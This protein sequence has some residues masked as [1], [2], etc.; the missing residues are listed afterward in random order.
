MIAK[1]PCPCC[2]HQ[3]AETDALRWNSETRTL[4]GRGHIVQLS[5]IRG[6]I[7]D[8]LW[9]CWPSGHMVSLEEL[10]TWV[11]ADDPDGGPES[12]NVISVQ[13]NHM[14]KFLAPFGLSIRGRHGYLIYNVAE[15]VAA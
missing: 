12:V 9:R 11:Y 8:K 14:R 5:P 3:I 2:G 13:L 15:Q 6:R 4:S 10:M 7:F 1:T